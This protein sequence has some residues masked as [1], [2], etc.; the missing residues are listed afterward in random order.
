M[1][2]KDEI[3]EHAVTEW[4]RTPGW[5]SLHG[6]VFE[7]AANALEKEHSEAEIFRIAE[8]ENA[9]LR[10][11]ELRKLILREHGKDFNE[12]DLLKF[13]AEA[14]IDGAINSERIASTLE[15]MKGAR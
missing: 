7:M 5:D 1:K 13:I 6:T 4:K 9:R 2:R 15:S 3:L 11:L 14:V 8:I 12:R 10:D